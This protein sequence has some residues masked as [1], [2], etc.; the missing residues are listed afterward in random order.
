MASVEEERLGQ[1]AALSGRH[2]A[3]PLHAKSLHAIYIHLA[4]LTSGV[5]SFT[6]GHG[7]CHH[8]KIPITNLLLQLQWA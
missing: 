1:L 6:P 3:A 2:A 7:K 5:C 8:V 4:G